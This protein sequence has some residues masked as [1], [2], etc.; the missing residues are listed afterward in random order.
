ML[1]SL[2][3]HTSTKCFNPPPWKPS[4]AKN[5]TSMR[6]SCQSPNKLEE[7]VIISL[8][9][10][11]SSDSWTARKAATSC[12]SSETR[13]KAISSIRRLRR[14]SKVKCKNW[15]SN[16]PETQKDFT[17]K[18][19]MMTKIKWKRSKS[20]RISLTKAG[21]NKRWKI[22]RICWKKKCLAIAIS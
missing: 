17:K 18:L 10:W 14:N 9:T 13:S 8:M 2:R 11:T 4:R 20:S 1:T 3:L 22:R 6:S 19:Q 15:S 5:R 7:Q 12:P 21:H 16:W